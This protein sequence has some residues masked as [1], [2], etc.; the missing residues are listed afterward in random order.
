MVGQFCKPVLVAEF[1]VFIKNIILI[2]IIIFIIVAP[3]QRA[4]DV[5]LKSSHWA[6]G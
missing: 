3:W 5:I 4:F 2:I 1:V 6:D